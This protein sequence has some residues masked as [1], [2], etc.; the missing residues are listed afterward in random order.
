MLA[1]PPNQ[2]FYSL[3]KWMFDFKITRLL[4]LLFGDCAIIVAFRTHT[5]WLLPFDR[6]IQCNYLIS[7]TR[8]QTKETK[9]L[10]Y[11]WNWTLLYKQST[12]AK[13]KNTQRTLNHKKYFFSTNILCACCDTHT[14]AH[15][16]SELQIIILK[17]TRA[18]LHHSMTVTCTRWMLVIIY[19]HVLLL[20]FAFYL[21]SSSRPRA[22][23][24]VNCGENII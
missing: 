3:L 13:L 16:K 9:H 2:A 24:S 23:K 8:L 22:F 18:H 12:A 10:S 6:V 5:Y 19:G 7:L 1:I 4:L 20:M 21:L 17:G 14:R 15:H 11:K